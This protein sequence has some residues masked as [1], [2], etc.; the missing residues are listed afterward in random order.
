[1]TDPEYQEALVKESKSFSIIWL[2]PWCIV[3]LI[4]AFN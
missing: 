2:L 1:M 4:V 3:V